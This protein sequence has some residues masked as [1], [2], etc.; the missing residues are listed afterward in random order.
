M[1]SAEFCNK[2]EQLKQVYDDIQNLNNI[3][4]LQTN[5]INSLKQEITK[6]GYKV[7][8][9]GDGVFEFVKDEESTTPDGDFLNPIPYTIGMEVEQG[10]FYTDGDNIW[11][12]IKD[13]TSTTFDDPD[14]FDIITV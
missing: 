3:I 5:E 4:E 14:F 12:A 9:V 1:N 11:E 13:G 8:D 2:F 7:I 6:L 10:K